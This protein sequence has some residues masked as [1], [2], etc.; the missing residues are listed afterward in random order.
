MQPLCF[1]ARNSHW[2]KAAHLLHQ[3]TVNSPAVSAGLLLGFVWA[4][5]VVKGISGTGSQLPFRRFMPMM[6][7]L[8]GC[9]GG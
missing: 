2:T 1:L 3:C 9:R 7:S 6:F 8:C 5:T 4:L